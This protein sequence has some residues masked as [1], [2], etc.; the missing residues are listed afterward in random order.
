MLLLMMTTPEPPPRGV[1]ESI[2]GTAE[3]FKIKGPARVCFNEGAIDLRAG[4]TSYLDYMGIHST[5][6]RIHGPNGDFTVSESDA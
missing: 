2:L 4:E 6:I 1:N 3:E 5:A